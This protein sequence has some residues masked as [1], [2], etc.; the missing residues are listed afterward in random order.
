MDIIYVIDTF[1]YK[2]I[3]VIIYFLKV[4]VCEYKYIEKEGKE[5]IFIENSGD[6]WG[7]VEGFGRRR[8]V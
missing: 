3:S 6:F 1:I 4:Y 7:E 5:S 2:I 8:G